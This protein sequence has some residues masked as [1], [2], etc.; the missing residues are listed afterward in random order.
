MFY[1][2]LSSMSTFTSN[3]S[4]IVSA[5]AYY[6]VEKWPAIHQNAPATATSI[7]LSSPRQTYDL[8]SVIISLRSRIQ[9]IL[10]R[11]DSY[12]SMRQSFNQLN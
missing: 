1:T 10:N 12:A 11:T 7:I 4:R 2:S 5:V 8:N 9:A 6:K 3:L